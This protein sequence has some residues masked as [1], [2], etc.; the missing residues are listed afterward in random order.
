M[1]SRC[2]GMETAQ[3]AVCFAG[4]PKT[5]TTSFQTVLR[6]N[7]RALGL[8]GYQYL[9]APNEGAASASI[10]DCGNGNDFYRSVFESQTSD[11]DPSLELL[12]PT[13]ISR[14]GRSS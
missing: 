3:R 7:R 11:L 12:T 6:C 10:M 2:L 13:E 14:L 8:N 5:G 9:G 4:L 1:A